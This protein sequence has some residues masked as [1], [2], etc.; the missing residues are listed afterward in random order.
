[1]SVAQID[2]IAIA[3]ELQRSSTLPHPNQSPEEYI[4][5]ASL[6]ALQRAIRAVGVNVA[7]AATGTGETS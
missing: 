1:M 6:L 3:E 4:L 7:N 2:Y 5:N